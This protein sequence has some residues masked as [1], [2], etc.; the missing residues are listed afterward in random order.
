MDEILLTAIIGAG[1]GLVG[2]VVGS[3]LSLVGQYIIFKFEDKRWK[4]ERKIDLLKSKKGKFGF[5]SAI[6]LSDDQI[7]KKIGEIIDSK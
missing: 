1:A 4:K 6:P 5:D 2:V 3:V 7:D